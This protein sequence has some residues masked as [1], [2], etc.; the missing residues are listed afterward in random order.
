MARKQTPPFESLRRSSPKSAAGK[1]VWHLPQETHDLFAR[2]CGGCRVLY[3]GGQGQADRGLAAGQRSRCRD[4]GTGAFFGESC[5]AGQPVRMATATAA[6]R[7]QS[8]A[9]R[10]RRH[11]P[12]AA[13]GT[14]P[15]PSCLWPICWRTPFASKRTWWISSLIPARSGSRGCCC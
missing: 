13:R 8:R 5:L 7:L 1:R 9:D 4:A 12:R 14:R 3:P 10:Q 6:R 11:D 15:S 2:G